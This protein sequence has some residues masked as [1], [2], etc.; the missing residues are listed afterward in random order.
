[1]TLT[2]D[3]AAGNCIHETDGRLGVPAPVRYFPTATLPVPLQLGQGCTPGTFP[4]PSQALHFPEPLQT[5]HLMFFPV[6]LL[7]VL[8]E[9]PQA[10]HFPEDWQAEQSAGKRPVSLHAVQGSMRGVSMAVAVSSDR[11]T[12]RWCWA[13]TTIT[14]V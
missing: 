11:T 3:R 12:E 9:P 1:M 5:R 7:A 8:P 4:E 10:L 2:H 14:F 6:I 13:A